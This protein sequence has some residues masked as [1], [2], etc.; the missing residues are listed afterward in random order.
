MRCEPARRRFPP[1]ALNNLICGASLH[2]SCVLFPEPHEVPRHPVC[3]DNALPA[4]PQWTPWTPR[5]APSSTR[6]PSTPSHAR[7]EVA[8]GACSDTNRAT[9]RTT[10]HADS[11]RTYPTPGTPRAATGPSRPSSRPAYS[12][13]T[14]G[15]PVLSPTAAWVC[16]GNTDSA[17]A[18]F[19]FGNLAQLVCPFPP[20]RPVSESGVRGGPRDHFFNRLPQ[21]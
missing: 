9:Y 7:P 18:C 12:T 17:A 16:R 4:A 20:A 14:P 3:C 10:V 2:S 5:A 8:R 21:Q 13:G 11:R 19:G 6:A 1:A 15:M